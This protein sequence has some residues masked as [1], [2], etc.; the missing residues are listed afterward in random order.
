MSTQTDAKALLEAAT[1]EAAQLEGEGTNSPEVVT[2]TAETV[3]AAPTEPAKE[4]SKQS[5]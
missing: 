2:T 4:E 5:E 1:L 3:E